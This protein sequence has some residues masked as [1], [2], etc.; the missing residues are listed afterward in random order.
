M[1]IRKVNL[2]DRSEWIDLRTQLW[3]NYKLE[4][5][6][7][8]AER[9][10]RDLDWVVFV[11]EQEERLVGFIE[12]SIRNKA[13]GCKTSKIGYIE[14][15]YVVPELR[16]Q[17]VGRKLVHSSERWAKEM[18]CTEMASDTTSEYPSSPAAHKAL[19]YH[20]VKRRFFFQKSI[21]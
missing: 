2:E 13:P 16:N 5:L 1:K 7:S 3:P 20:E 6:N 19:G 10:L 11:A 9:I 21:S 12:C 8:E 4:Q 15:W 17:G 18:G 14:G